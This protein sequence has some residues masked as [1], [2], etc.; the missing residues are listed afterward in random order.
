MRLQG[1]YKA[2]NYGVID[3]NKGDDIITCLLCVLWCKRTER[4]GGQREKIMTLHINLEFSR[5]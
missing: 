3:L 1:I 5:Q 4:G 2:C